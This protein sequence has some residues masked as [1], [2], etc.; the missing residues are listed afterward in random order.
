M[1]HAAAPALDTHDRIALGEHAELDSLADAPL[2]TL[3]DVLLPVDT[4]EVGLGL[5]E[6]E[7][8][9]ATVEVRVAG[10]SGVAGDHDNGA[11]RAVFGDHSSGGATVHG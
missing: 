7:G 8:V 3:V 6:E 5:R 11:Y 10:G 2:E 1:A 9:D 4:A